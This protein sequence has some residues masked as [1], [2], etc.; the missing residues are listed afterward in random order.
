MSKDEVC[1]SEEELVALIHSEVNRQLARGVPPEIDRSDLTSVANE[2]LALALYRGTRALRLAI[3]CDILDFLRSRRDRAQ[4]ETSMP[5]HEKVVAFDRTVI[6]HLVYGLPSMQHEA[7]YLHYY[8]D[9][10][11][12][13][14]AAIMSTTEDNVKYWLKTARKKLQSLLPF[15]TS[16]IDITAERGN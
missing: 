13:E 10:S 12:P 9:Y 15:S 1:L 4:Y 14:V 2:A 5:E 11:V 6:T 16:S 7:V 8:Q 3:R